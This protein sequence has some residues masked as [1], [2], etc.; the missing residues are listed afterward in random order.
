MAGV[1]V[2]GFNSS[3]DA[4]A[5]LVEGGRVAAAVEEERLTRVKH[6]SGFPARAIRWILEER[7][8]TA[9]DLSAVAYV[10]NPARGLLRFAWHVARHLPGSLAY[11]RSHPGTWRSIVGMRKTLRRDFGFRGPFVFVDHHLCHAASSFYASPFSSAAILTLDG[12]GEW[13][14]TL[15]ARGRE[16]AIERLGAVGYPHSL[17]KVYEAVTQ[18]LGF[19]PMSGEGRVM[20]LAGHGEP[21]FIDLFRE[22]VRETRGGYRVDTSFFRYHLG[23]D[24]KFS[25]GLERV[26]GPPRDEGAEITDRHRDIAASLQL[27]LEEV[28]LLLARRLRARTGEDDLCVAGGVGFNS[29]M[30]GRLVRESGFRRVFITPAANDSG[31]ALG[32][33][34]AVAFRNLGVR[35]RVALRS[36][37]LGPAFEESAIEAALRSAAVPFRRSAD[38]PREAAGM[39]A[40]GLIIGWF[41]GAMEYGPRALGNRS[42][43][44]D[45]RRAEMKDI[46]NQ[47]VK[48]RESFRPFAPAVP[49]DEAHRFFEGIQESP[50]MLKVF[51]VR[52][53]A[54]PLIPAVTHVDGTA[55]VQTLTPG[56]NGPFHDLVCAFGDL[57]GVPVVL[58]T[59]F[60]VNGQP[61]VCTPREAIATFAESGLDALVLP[62]FIVERGQEGDGA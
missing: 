29:V 13:E 19:R 56:D 6:Q 35:E 3:H 30:N 53:A 58:N 10:W 42:I 32:A 57:T 31:A 52:E 62:P 27:R 17:G 11:L 18:F 43:L 25:P 15:L 54:R 44:A 5:V 40:R 20:G 22:I 26:L 55:R 7:G 51:A 45:P 34:L 14:T 36:A 50:F 16:G 39:L 12:T 41:H 61:I 9:A 38:A 8:L 60:N 23:A 4:C 47:R 1:R 59:S 46:L 2:L 24:V 28:A 49:L 21:R 33:A 37:A 48:R